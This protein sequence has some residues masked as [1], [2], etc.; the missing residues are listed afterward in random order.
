[1]DILGP[2]NLQLNIMHPND[3]FKR[4]D[5][6]SQCANL[7]EGEISDIDIRLLAKG[8]WGWF[9]I[10]DIAF[11]HDN[12]GNVSQV[13][14][15]VRDIREKKIT[16]DNLKKKQ[17]L[18]EGVLNAPNL[19]I[20]I[21]KAIR[22]NQGIILDY[23]FLLTSKSATE[24]YRRDDLVGKWLFEVFPE[25]REQYKEL[26]KVV[27]EGNRIV[28]NITVYQ[29]NESKLFRI[30]NAKME[31]GF[32]S[33]WENITEQNQSEQA[34][35]VHKRL[36]EVMLQK[37]ASSIMALK[38]IRNKENEIIDLEYTFTNDR[39]L[40]SV[41]R[42]SLVGKKFA[43]EF[44]YVVS[45]GLFD[46]YKKV[47]ETGIELNEEMYFDQ[48]GLNTWSFVHAQKLDDGILVTY[49]DITSVKQA[50]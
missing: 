26:E 9:R 22:N 47:I 4:M 44:P 28:R 8:D 11:K 13:I 49:M 31:G 33:V 6:L 30:S 48:D 39:T 16:E 15:I 17:L 12:N 21:F 10:R 36:L 29:N 19:G 40:Q 38:A 27:N 20:S 5:Q 35:Q 37:T 46:K 24:L 50:G 41:N 25:Y 34:L 43:E 45:S 3:Y 18:L 2:E 14:G 23:E 32:S 1:M 42:T 7:G